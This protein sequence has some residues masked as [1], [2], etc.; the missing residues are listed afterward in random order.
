MSA[1]IT[2]GQRAYEEMTRLF[3]KQ[4]DAVRTLGIKSQRVIYDWMDGVAPSA[5]YLQRLHYAGADVVYILTGIRKEQSDDMPIPKC[6]SSGCKDQR[7]C[8]WYFAMISKY[9]KLASPSIQERCEAYK[10]VFY[11]KE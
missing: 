1:E 3:E 11:T 7:G 6:V 4:I 9:P 8:S 2:I 10:E 5:K